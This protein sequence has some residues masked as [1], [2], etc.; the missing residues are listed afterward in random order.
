[1]LSL[2]ELVQLAKT[3]VN[4]LFCCSHLDRLHGA[5]RLA[6]KASDLAGRKTTGTP[7]SLQTMGCRVREHADNQRG[8]PC[9]QGNG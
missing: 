3:R 6:D 8:Q 4:A 9:Q 1:M 2:S 5:I 7:G